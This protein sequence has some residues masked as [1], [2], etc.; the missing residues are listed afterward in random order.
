MN[1]FRTPR[2][3]IG[4][5]IAAG[6]GI[7]FLALPVLSLLWRAIDY[8][9]AL[10]AERTRDVLLDAI[11]LSLATSMVAMVLVVAF[12]T[13]LAWVL[14]RSR[15]RAAHIADAIIDLPILLPPAVAG[16]AMLTAFGRMGTLGGWLDSYGVQ[17]GFTSVAVVLAQVFVSAPFYVRSVRAGF[18]RVVREVEESA[19]DL[20]APPFA[21]F[22]KITLPIARNSIIAGLVIAWARALGE[23][24]A[25]IMFAGNRRGITQTMPLAIYERYGSGDLPAAIVMSIVL[26]GISMIFL[27]AVRIFEVR[28]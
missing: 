23:F 19:A 5:W 11:V 3:W 24:G 18:M 12:G 2:F 6:I 9:Q 7:A 15:S 10:T 20:G 28:D 27:V 21:V 22:C 16:I 13:P 4:M 1:L 25:T 26:L 17:I 8:R 14:A